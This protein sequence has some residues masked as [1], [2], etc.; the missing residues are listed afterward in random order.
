MK[1][2]GL[3]LLLAATAI[4]LGACDDR[5]VGHSAASSQVRS[6]QS[7]S[8]T[9]TDIDGTYILEEMDETKTLTIS[10]GQ[11]SLETL[12]KDGEKEVEQVTVDTAKNQLRIGEDY[13]TY[14]LE[15]DK[16]TLTEDDG[17]ASIYQKK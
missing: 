8:T 13:H 12:E 11:G 2:R 7:S 5:E 10:K 6:S 4:F 3:I 17:E 1:R 9:A 14:R 15:G 16:L